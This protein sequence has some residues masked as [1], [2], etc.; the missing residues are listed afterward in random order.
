MANNCFH[1]GQPIPA[2]A[3]YNVEIDGEERAMCCVGCEA[4]AKA[5]V[6]N[7]LTDFYRFRTDKANTPQSL[8]PEELRELQIFDNENLQKSFVRAEAS[9]A[10]REASLILEGIVC[11]ACIW[12]NE[13]HVQ[14]IPGVLSF[15]INYSTHRASLK[16]DNDQIKLSDIL[17]AITD[18][19]YH[20]HPFDPGRLE[21]LQ[22]KEK[23]S[24]LR[25]IAIAG[26]GMMQVMMLSL[27]LYVGEVSDMTESMQQFIRWISFIIASVVIFFASKVF[28]ISAWR[29]LRRKKFGMDIPVALAMGAAYTSSVWATLTNSGEVYF[30]SVI[31][32]TFFLLTGRYLEMMAR[33]RSGQVAEAL[34]RLIPATAHRI[35]EGKQETVAVSELEIGDTVLI[36]PGESIPADGVV[37]DGTSSVNES[38]LTGESIPLAKTPQSRLIGGTSNI[39]SPLQMRVEK[40]GES[41]V[42]SAIIRLL[43][44]AQSEK[45]DLAKLADKVA[46]WFVLALLIVASIV[47]MAWYTHA[48]EQAFWVTLSVLVVT[49]PCALSLATPTALT[50]ATGVLTEKGILTTRGHALETLAKVTDVIF[51][52]T[53]TLTHGRLQLEK[54]NVLGSLPEQ[55][56]LEIA[57][58]LEASSEHPVAKA[59][60]REGAK[61]AELSAIQAE[62]GQGI[63]GVQAD[64]H[65]RLGT[66]A[67]VEA[68]AG[69]ALPAEQRNQTQ[70]S[71]VYLATENEWLA[72]FVLQDEMRAESAEVVC[73]L[74]QANVHV[75]LFSGDQQSTVDE[76]AK[77]LNISDAKGGLLPQEKLQQMQALQAEDRRVAMIGDGVNDAPVLAGA[78]V[79][80]AMGSGSQLAQAS[81]DMVLLSENLQQFP[82]AIKTAKRMQNIIRQNFAWAIGYNLV[83]LPLAASGMIAP[84]MA[85]I[86][87]SLSS[88]IVVLNALRLKS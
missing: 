11:A 10:I 70:N 5:I 40:L 1:C 25:R 58:G 74:Q 12:L 39:E 43:E 62:S 34:V 6:E 88:L 17:K 32:F 29:D 27:A 53:G 7:D 13:H 84:W 76:V 71:A 15:K 63:Q 81:A 55:Q 18:I 64:K 61:I 82:A 80:L 30:D 52:K 44:R 9:G 78:N 42:L 41:T 66:Y 57:S 3:D 36:K 2:G 16:W 85:A 50:V 22:K 59:I 23:S 8:V 68:L 86:G 83:A 38:L 46:S 48:P 19:G 79:S 33:H 60:L 54:I 37:I 4:V 28:F 65:Y 72:V 67:Y 73:R 56:V 20:A 77:K 24:A 75:H 49:C 47:F 51:D 21:S 69:S 87:M 26:L 31:M 14:S 45:P 35:K